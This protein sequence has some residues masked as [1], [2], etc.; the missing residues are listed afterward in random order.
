MLA[1]KNLKVIYRQYG[2]KSSIAK[3]IV[4]HFP[5]HRVYLE[6]FCGGAAV[7]LAKEPSFIE[8]I[9]DID[10]N[11]IEMFKL[12]RKRP[13]ELAAA[14]WATPY[15]PSN[16]HEKPETEIEKAVQVIAK[17]QQFYS[18]DL[19]SSTWAIDKC[20]NKHKPK[21]KVWADWFRRVLP[22]AERFK[23]VQILQECALKAIE[24]VY[25]Q[26]NCLIYVDPPYY[27][28][29]DEYC[30]AVD[31]ERMVDMLN[32]AKAKVI[33]SEYPEADNF[34]E[35]WRIIEKQTAG[36]CRTGAHKRRAK[37]KYE[38]LYC[39]FDIQLLNQ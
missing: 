1:D 17:S 31:Y 22:I 9:N 37:T 2:G 32:T 20:G 3:W 35:G 15:S 19:N 23:P 10:G 5:E 18:G 38:R 26:D 8:I 33:I 6:P 4:S 14:L 7:L 34:Y 12:L 27:G 28:H 30:Y 39:N 36:R 25:M 24:R 13:F 11:I 21:G 29:E 16:W